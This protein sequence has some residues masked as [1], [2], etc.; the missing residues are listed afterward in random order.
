VKLAVNIQKRQALKLA[1]AAATPPLARTMKVF[2]TGS[3]NHT[4]TT[5]Q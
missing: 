1:Q 3:D 5:L 2:S 4:Y